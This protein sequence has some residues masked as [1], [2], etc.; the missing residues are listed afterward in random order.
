[1]NLDKLLE[2][3]KDNGIIFDSEGQ[4]LYALETALCFKSDCS[5]RK[6]SCKTS[7]KNCPASNHTALKELLNDL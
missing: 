2:T 7:C 1:M 4:L 5:Q 3:L 6:T